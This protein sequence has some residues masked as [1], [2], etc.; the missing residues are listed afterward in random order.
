MHEH[1]SVWTG[2]LFGPHVEH[3]ISGHASMHRFGEHAHDPMLHSWQGGGFPTHVPAGQSARLTEPS[4]HTQSPLE[5][6]GGRSASE[7]HDW[8]Q[9][10]ASPPHDPPLPPP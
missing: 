5:H 10:G 4:G 9:V 7:L 3:M 6:L 8:A 2:S 1:V